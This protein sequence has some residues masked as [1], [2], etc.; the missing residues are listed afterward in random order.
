MAE[1]VT[2]GQLSQVLLDLG[3][4]EQTVPQSHTRYCH[5]ESETVILLAAHAPEAAA[6]PFDVKYVRRVLDETG[7]L[8]A[9]E[10]ERRLA[11]TCSSHTA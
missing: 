5:Q 10:F 8:D 7:L 2:Y 1:E 9:R 11:E 6:R 4:V 3:F